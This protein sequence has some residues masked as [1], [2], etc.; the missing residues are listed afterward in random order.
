MKGNDTFFL[1]FWKWIY[2]PAYRSCYWALPVCKQTNFLWIRWLIY[3]WTSDFGCCFRL[4]S[5]TEEY[6]RNNYITME[7]YCKKYRNKRMHY[8]YAKTVKIKR[9]AFWKHSGNASLLRN[10]QM[11]KN[12]SFDNWINQVI[13]Q[14]I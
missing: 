13:I 3:H 8:S 12:F 10:R 4:P 2:Q 7:G 5:P 1:A 11:Y 6:N 14:L 9:C